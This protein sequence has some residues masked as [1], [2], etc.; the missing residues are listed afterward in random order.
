MASIRRILCAV[1]FSDVSRR[2]FD[3]AAALA[4]QQDATVTLLYVAPVP[5]P[6][7]AGLPGYPAVVSLDMGAR[8]HWTAELRRLAE[9]ARDVRTEVMVEQG[10]AVAEIMAKAMATGADLVVMGTHGRSGFERWLLG[11]VADHILRKGTCPVLL[12][13]PRC[14]EA[15]HEGAFRR[16]LCPLDLFASSVTTLGQ[17]ARVARGAGPRARLSLLHVVDDL[18]QHEIALGRAGLE[19]A[20]YRRHREEDARARLAE[21]ASS[22]AAGLEVDISVATGTGWRAILNAAAETPPDLLVLGTHG[23]TADG[24][25]GSNADRVVREARCPVLVVRGRPVIEHVRELLHE[26]SRARPAGGRP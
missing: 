24:H 22:Q 1:D 13:S 9:R 17:A 3:Y 19:L 15:P 26:P 10:S 2:A 23:Q 18:P 11:S 12:V 5:V 14:P 4:R 6:L 20:A 8:A 21:L 25:L 7:S 16:I